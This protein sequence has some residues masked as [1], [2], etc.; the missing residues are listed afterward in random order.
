MANDRRSSAATNELVIT[1]E[2]RAS[3]EL[4]W[5]A[6]TNARHFA[7]WFGPKD[8]EVPFCELEPREGG[9]LRFCHRFA[10]GEELWVQGVFREV[11]APERLV[12]SL[13]FADRAGQSAGHPMF[14]DWPRDAT[15]LTTV[16]FSELARR[17]EPRTL[18]EIRQAI[19]PAEYAELA[20]IRRERQLAREGW[21][22]TLDRLDEH[23]RGEAR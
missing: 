12:F 1:R 4:V 7:R 22:E 8:I 21:T 5:S 19:L 11:T 23:L 6:W 14:P 10:T 15:F 3:R 18:L 13:A 2:L 20:M 17:G 16:T 9:A